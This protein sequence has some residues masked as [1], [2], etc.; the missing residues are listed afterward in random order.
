M[1]ACSNRS[2]LSDE[3][4]DSDTVMVSKNLRNNDGSRISDS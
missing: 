2:G 4:T 1:L 3:N